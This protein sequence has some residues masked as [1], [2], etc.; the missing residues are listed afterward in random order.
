MKGVGNERQRRL[1]MAGASAKIGSRRNRGEMAKAS[2]KLVA[3]RKCGGW[4]GENVAA[5]SSESGVMAG[6]ML[7]AKWR[8]GAGISSMAAEN[9]IVHRDLAMLANMA[10]AAAAAESGGGYSALAAGRYANVSLQKC[11]I[12]GKQRKA[13]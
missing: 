10:M 13:M 4:R 5:A 12:S 1:K 9:G 2:R 6:S 8:R 7:A 3:W 11:T